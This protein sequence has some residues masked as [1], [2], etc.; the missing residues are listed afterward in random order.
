MIET[1]VSS[2]PAPTHLKLIEVIIWHLLF[3]KIRY[4]RLGLPSERQ[5][6]LIRE[7]DRKNATKYLG[8][9]AEHVQG[10]SMDCH[11]W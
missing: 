11:C 2:R 3:A 1:D 9:S 5:C 6:S 4:V 10:K 8:G 7:S